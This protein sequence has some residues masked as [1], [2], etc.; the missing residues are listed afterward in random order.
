M[1][2]N[3]GVVVDDNSMQDLGYN[4][5]DVFFFKGNYSNGS[6]ESPTTP[7]GDSENPGLGDNDKSWLSGLFSG[8]TQS[9]ENAKNTIISSVSSA[10]QTV[11]QFILD[12]I[13]AIFVP[14]SDFLTEKI[15]SVKEK[16]V[17]IDNISEAFDNVS[18]LLTDGNEAIP[19][20]T[21]DL[22]KAESNY[23][24]GSTVVALDMAWYSRYK[25]YVDGVIIAFSYISFIFLIFKRAPEIIKGSGAITKG[26]E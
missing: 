20:M 9:L 6:S 14:D 7:P 24:Y 1:Y 4:K 11:G 26:L 19:Q 5:G 25:P 3:T 21:I 2:G 8:I 18:S 15:D 23:N 22:S 12:G 16:F 13:T 10:F 17:F